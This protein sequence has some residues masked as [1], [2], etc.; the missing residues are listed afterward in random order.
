[1]KKLAEEPRK[2]T[3]KE[4]GV[5]SVVLVK[6]KV[7]VSSKYGKEYLTL[8]DDLKMPKRTSTTPINNITSKI[9]ISRRL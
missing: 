3:M 2:I 4:K 1:M 7:G 6:G 8:L 9:G 5:T